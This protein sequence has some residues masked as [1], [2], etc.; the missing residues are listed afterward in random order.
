[1]GRRVALL[2]RPGVACDR[3]RGALAEAGAQLVLEA[4]PLTL[5]P[6]ALDAAQA[7]V[8]MVALDA[9]TEDALERFEAAL[10]DPAIE[11]IFEEAELAAQAR[12]LGSGA[13]GAPPCRQVARPRRC[14]AARR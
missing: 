12:R 11:V 9:Q 2:A 3:L 8:V 5:D 6:A 4:D 1:M 14:A 13:L 7:Q 10:Q